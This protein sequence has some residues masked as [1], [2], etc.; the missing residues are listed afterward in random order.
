MVL[1]TKNVKQIKRK[2]KKVYLKLMAFLVKPVA[3]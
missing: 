2:P 3:L 1:N